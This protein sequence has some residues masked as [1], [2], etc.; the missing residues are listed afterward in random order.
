M[1]C[2]IAAQKYIRLP[3]LFYYA[4][5]PFLMV[6]GEVLVVFKVGH[7][8]FWDCLGLFFE[9]QRVFFVLQRGFFQFPRSLLGI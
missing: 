8:R 6:L 1:C 5:N 2:I 7:K 3:S 4:I 9:L